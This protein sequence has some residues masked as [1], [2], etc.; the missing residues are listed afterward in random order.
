MIEFEHI[1]QEY[2][3]GVA[4]PGQYTFPFSF[5]IPQWLPSSFLSYGEW[6][7][8]MQITYSLRTI[9]SEHVEG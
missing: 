3:T 5:Q 4:E 2:K 8:K 9:M 1:L 6:K 7:S